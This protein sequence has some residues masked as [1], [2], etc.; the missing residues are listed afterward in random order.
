MKKLLLG[1]CVVVFF[2][3]TGCVSNELAYVY[4]SGI[5]EDK[6]SFL[7]VPNYAVVKQ[8]GDKTV[9]WKTPSLAMRP[10]R[11]GVPSGE[12]TFIIDSDGVASAGLAPVKNKSYTKNFE[13][14]KA[15][16]LIHRTGEKEIVLIDLE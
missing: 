7:W 3:F 8:F 9:E 11:V 13:A 14:G 16:Q 5:P 6:M 12:Y 1:V 15:Y 10:V 2:G 4:D